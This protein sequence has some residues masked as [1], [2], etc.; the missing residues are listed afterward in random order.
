MAPIFVM[1][2]KVCSNRIPLQ[3]TQIEFGVTFTFKLRQIKK[4][5]FL[6]LYQI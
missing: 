6:Q 2:C 4:F 3:L 5:H 1:Y